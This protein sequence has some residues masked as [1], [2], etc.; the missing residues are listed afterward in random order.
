MKNILLLLILFFKSTLPSIAQSDLSVEET[1]KY[2]NNKLRD[3]PNFDRFGKHI[4]AIDISTENIFII[5]VYYYEKSLEYCQLF[6]RETQCL[7]VQLSRE[8]NYMDGGIKLENVSGDFDCWKRDCITKEK[9]ES[10][11]KNSWS[12]YRVEKVLFSN[13]SLIGESLCSAFKHLFEKIA[14]DPFYQ[15]YVDPNDPFAKKKTP[16]N[17]NLNVFG[18][19]SNSEVIEMKKMPG[20]TFEVPVI[21]NGVLKINF[22]FDSGASD[23]SISPDVALTLIRTGTVKESDFIGTQRY[24]FADGSSA[25]SKVFYIRE[26]QLGK[27]KIDNVKASISK[28]IEAPMLLGQSVLQRFGKVTIDNKNQQLIIEE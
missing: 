24:S 25:L 20:G 19:S 2:I 26:L 15:P 13:A 11:V 18:G 12:N 9:K 28:S 21:I 17:S 6:S 22:I 16:T 10:S 3:N 5:Y 14:K 1:I 27:H 7:N 23:V 8:C 4:Y